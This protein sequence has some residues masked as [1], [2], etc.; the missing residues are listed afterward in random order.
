MGLPKALKNKKA[1]TGTGSKEPSKEKTK[2]TEDNRQE[3]IQQQ[4]AT[5]NNNGYYR[6][7]LLGKLEEIRESL[8]I[9]NNNIASLIEQNEETTEETNDEELDEP[10]LPEEEEEQ[11]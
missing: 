9:L 6:Y 2:P 11:D 3:R 8:N 4:M 1:N 7:H 10:P 5:L